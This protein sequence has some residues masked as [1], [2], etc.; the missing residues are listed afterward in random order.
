[1][2]K[3]SASGTEDPGF[4]SRLRWDFS[5]SSHTSDLNILSNAKFFR[6][7]EAK[8]IFQTNIRAQFSAE[9]KLMIVSL[10]SSMDSSSI[11]F[12]CHLPVS[13]FSCVRS[14]DVDGMSVFGGFGS[15][16][17]LAEL[18]WIS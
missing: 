4:E 15:V 7:K 1:M 16:N 13:F 17:T 18:V 8:S 12:D 3:A 2:V 9:R 5:G 6:T 10:Q 11:N 14:P